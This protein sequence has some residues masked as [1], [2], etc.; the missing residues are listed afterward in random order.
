MNHNKTANVS[1]I[2]NE[3]GKKILQMFR[4]RPERNITLFS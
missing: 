4:W 1:S 2:E 3:T